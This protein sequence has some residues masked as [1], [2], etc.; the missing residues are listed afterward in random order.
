MFG[1]LTALIG[2]FHFDCEG[3]P[4]FLYPFVLQMSAGER[5]VDSLLGEKG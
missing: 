5:Q 2:L 1:Q 3:V 4:P